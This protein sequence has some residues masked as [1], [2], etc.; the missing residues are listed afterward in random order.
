MIHCATP[1]MKRAS[2]RE[3]L[4]RPE[5][6]FLME[7]H[8]GLSARIVEESGFEAIWASGRSAR[9]QRNLATLVSGLA[10]LGLS[11]LLHPS[12][13]A[14][15]IVTY[16]APSGAW[17]DFSMLYREL[18]QRGFAIYPGKTARVDSFRI[19][20]IGAVEPE[21]LETFVARFHDVVA[22]MKQ[23]SPAA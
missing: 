5:I 14:P 4:A 3:I 17:Y 21:D 1:S 10:P 19:G 2:L 23:R 12:V 9:Y 16:A 8:N 22:L 7:A 20:C 13:Q 18:L 15:I 6:A 11:P